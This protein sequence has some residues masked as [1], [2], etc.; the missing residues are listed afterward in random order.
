MA[1]RSTQDSRLKHCGIKRESHD[2][3]LQQCID[4]DC[5]TS[6]RPPTLCGQWGLEAGTLRS[7]LNDGGLSPEDQATTRERLAR[8]D[9]FLSQL[10]KSI[11]S[12][13]KVL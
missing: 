1:A 11:K 3:H 10:D 2:H 8:L 6:A 5:R 4:R 7:V 9:D 13:D 12:K